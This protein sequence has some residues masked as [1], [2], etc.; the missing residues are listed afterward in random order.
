MLNRGIYLS[1]PNSVRQK[2]LQARLQD[3]TY[4]LLESHPAPDVTN[5]TTSYNP[6]KHTQSSTMGSIEAT[7]IGFI[8]LGAMGSPMAGHLATKLPAET[9]IF[10]FDVVQSLMD[11][12]CQ[13]HPHKVTAC[14][15]AREVAEQSV[16]C[17]L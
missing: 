13:Q 9:H 6:S 12:I 5:Q 16:R 2:G 8:G 10:V 15:N 3:T 11:Q 7:N 17:I 1:A 4:Q 14:A